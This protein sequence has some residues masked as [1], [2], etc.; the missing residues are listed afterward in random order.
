MKL[1]SK[2]VWAEG[3]HLAPH[4]F[5]AQS[6][7]F[8]ESVH[9]ATAGLWNHAYGFAGCQLDSEA[10]RNGTVSL[11]SARGMFEDGLP[12]DFP[13]CDPLPATLNIVDRFSPTVDYVRVALAVPRWFADGQNCSVNGEPEQLH[14]YTGM[15][16]TLPDENTG[17][18]D[19]PIRLGH[20]N[21]RLILE[22]EATEDLL[23]L[24]L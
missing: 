18:D 16:H 8:E 17:R 14:R 7:Y 5:Q 21:I 20:K 22:S 1:Q 10:L 2:V 3:M 9:F 13:E 24:P 15:V 4:H 6:R 11:L 23:T 19:K 12:F